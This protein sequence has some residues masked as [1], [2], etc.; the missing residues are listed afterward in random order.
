MRTRPPLIALTLFVLAPALVVPAGSLAAEPGTTTVP[1]PAEATTPSP[2]PPA[3]APPP[4]PT[5]EVT[6]APAVSSTPQTSATPLVQAQHAQGST[7]AA[8]AR[9]RH[10]APPSAEAHAGG[11]TGS[12][13]GAAP[14]AAA[15]GKPAPPPS[16][17]TPP[18]PLSL[19]ASLDGVP[20][21][22]IE[23]FRVPPFLL[24]IFQAAGSAYGIPWQVLAAINEVETDYGRD[25]SVSSAGA[26][27]WMQFLPAEW[28]QYGVDATDSGFEDPY[29]PT[30]AIFAAA[31]YLRA[32]GG[33]TNIRA[34]VYSYNHS[35]SYVSSVLL[36]AELLGG[37]PPQLLGA[38]VGL[39]EARFPVHAAAHFSDGFQTLPAEGTRPAQT[40]VGTTIY[41]QTGA[42][43]IAAQD[44]EIV[45]IGSSSSL[46]RFISL[47]DAFGNTYVYAQL[48]SI[49]SLYPVLRPVRATQGTGARASAAAAA[50]PPGEA[51]P[52]G[53]AT[54]GVQSGSSLADDAAGSALPLGVGAGLEAPPATEPAPAAPPAPR[55]SGVT[56]RSFREG[57]TEVY[58]H[59]LRPGVQV[60]AGTVLAHL[61]PSAD[62]LFQI[63]PAAAGAPL[64]DPKPILDSW[65]ALEN[66]AIHQDASKSA[67]PAA[68]LTAT[69]SQV[70]TTG[71]VLLESARQLGRL[72]IHDPS[73][74]LR[75][76]ERQVIQG[77][78][79]GRRLLAT[80]EF[81]SVSGL[82]PTVTGI[83]CGG[84]TPALE[85]NVRPASGGEKVDITAVNG[86]PIATHQGPGSVA[87]ATIDKLLEL[88]GSTRP[89][90]IVSP[91]AY[92]GAKGVVVR[93]RDHSYIELVFSAPVPVTK[94]AHAADDVLGASLSSNE[95]LQLIARLGE[96]PNP[97]VSSKPSAAAIPDQAPAGA[98]G[99]PPVQ[100]PRET[101]GGAGGND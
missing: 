92:A 48:G 66:T 3:Q 31:R 80:I 24:P 14:G 8:P 87:E 18:L 34:A 51:P 69:A 20:G 65:V 29:N 23:N 50:P 91:A 15:N 97:T 25:L 77:G 71:Q 38:V 81:L 82:K 62:M 32:A 37:T 21:F 54:A 72:V 67:A 28:A 42:P 78:D 57:S 90:Q 26:E 68:A 41:S 35:Q 56:V 64:I 88:Q 59:P 58:L 93:P 75:R 79:V 9:A 36:R 2:A 45:Q 63:R 84:S 99:A 96:V 33:D 89:R 12:T 47:R 52:S 10:G 98:S 6:P 13:G 43:V 4:A 60:I 16:T 94:L 55:P 40:L 101:E 17:F 44:G 73:V 74:R 19:S 7:R 49:A 53:P 11:A 22:F 46:G 61:G 76:C 70:L 95:W 83:T 39:T 27:G 5:V 85:G 30:D 86:L 100:A 1:A